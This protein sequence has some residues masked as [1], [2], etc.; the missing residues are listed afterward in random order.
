VLLVGAGLLLKS[1]RQLMELDP[2]FDPR[3]VLTLRLRL[4]DAKYR[5]PAQTTGFLK[6]VSRR[7]RFA[8][9]RDVSVA[10]SSHSADG[11]AM[12]VARR[13]TA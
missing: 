4:P 3:D 11:P 9:V 7:V 13:G 5:E 12:T 6:E 8:G 2:G 1:F 10:T